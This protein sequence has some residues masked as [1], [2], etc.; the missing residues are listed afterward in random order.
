MNQ[1]ELAQMISFEIKTLRDHM[2]QYIKTQSD[3]SPI[4]QY[5][6]EELD[7][8]LHIT[9]VEFDRKKNQPR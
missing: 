1:Q 8:Q 2:K 5:H 4:E 7:Y 9:A 3:I 6:F